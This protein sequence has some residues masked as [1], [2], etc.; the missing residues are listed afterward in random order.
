MAGGTEIGTRDVVLLDTSGVDANRS[1]T[2][3]SETIVGTDATGDE[4]TCEEPTADENKDGVEVVVAGEEAE[5]VGDKDAEE[6]NDVEVNGSAYTG[7]MTALPSNAVFDA[8]S[9][10]EG[11]EPVATARGARSGAKGDALVVVV[12]VVVVTAWAGNRCKACAV[13]T[14][15]SCC[16]AL[17]AENTRKNEKSETD[18]GGPPSDVIG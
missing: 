3:G 15:A 12:A 18:G 8:T 5:D 7:T 16:A 17:S 14:W 10:T 13:R 2:D 6:E 11:A 9:P 1:S 4:D